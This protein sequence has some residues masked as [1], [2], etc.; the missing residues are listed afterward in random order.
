MV[1]YDSATLYT[2]KETRV[3]C[4]D[5]HSQIAKIRR[6]EGG[7]WYAIKAALQKAVEEEAAPFAATSSLPIRSTRGIQDVPS[8]INTLQAPSHLAP[9]N[10]SPDPHRD[11]NVQNR[12][13]TP[14]TEATGI[15]T[16]VSE[17]QMELCS[18]IRIG[19]IDTVQ[20]L[21]ANGA[22]VHT[23]HEDSVDVQQDPFL[24]AAWFRQKRV[25]E[26]LVR[27]NP[28][29]KKNLLDEQCTALH[30]IF[31]PSGSD[32]RGPLTAS[33]VALLLRSGCDIEARD[34]YGQTPLLCAARSGNV[35]IV[36]CLVD[37][38]ADHEAISDLGFGVIHMAAYDDER[39]EVL[40]FFISRGV[41]LEK[42]SDEG[43][44]P[45]MISARRGQLKNVR[46][47]LDHGANVSHHNKYGWT[48]L[49]Y[50]KYYGHPQI[51]EMLL[52]YS[53]DPCAQTHQGLKPSEVEWANETN[54]KA[55]E[56]KR[57][58]SEEAKA[59]CLKLLRDA[60]KA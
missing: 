30:L 23:P 8:T 41:F 35:E 16:P 39:L 25:L 49:H 59:L 40:K 58:P 19:N 7:V 44:T 37:H 27:Y 54:L 43:F 26:I 24:L 46:W 34:Q 14:D 47:L 2:V 32:S 6:D 42:K 53:A 9:S 18:A 4:D 29:P 10:P 21:M 15:E 57:I 5:D 48:A 38:G 12:Q 1:T 20:R 28:D 3:G 17:L 13:E 60:E 45:L 55:S 31:Y 52:R 56:M 51:V 36:C 22:H 11:N 50:A 33:L